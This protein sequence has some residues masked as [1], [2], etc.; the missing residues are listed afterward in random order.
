MRSLS[1][2]PGRGA[3][4]VPSDVHLVAGCL[5]SPRGCQHRRGVVSPSA[6][7]VAGP[8]RC[9]PAA[10]RNTW[11]G[12]NVNARHFG[13]PVANAPPDGASLHQWDWS[14]RRC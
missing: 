5:T 11:P 1:S 8:R 2:R 6:T 9:W 13:V 10:C 7:Q 12:T 4:L 3:D 14:Y